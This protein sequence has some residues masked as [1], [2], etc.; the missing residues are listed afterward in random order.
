MYGFS[1]QKSGIGSNMIQSYMERQLN[2][3][4]SS[5]APS[6][7]NYRDK[8]ISFFVGALTIILLP[9]FHIGKQYFINLKPV[10]KDPLK[11]KYTAHNDNTYPCFSF[12]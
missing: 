2:T 10:V 1:K 8:V 7:T 6:V 11:H 3:L 4:H 12:K 9:Y 5:S